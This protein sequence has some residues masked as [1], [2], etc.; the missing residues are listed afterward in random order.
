VSGKDNP[1]VD[2]GGLF[3]KNCHVAIPLTQIKK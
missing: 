2:Q 1:P 3:L